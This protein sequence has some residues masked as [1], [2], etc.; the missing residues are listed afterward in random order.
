MTTGFSDR[1]KVNI[2]S[3]CL[4]SRYMINDYLNLMNM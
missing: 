4:S 3:I 1:D 2:S